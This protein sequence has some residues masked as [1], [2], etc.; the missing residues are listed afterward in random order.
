[1]SEIAKRYAKALYELDQRTEV[2]CQ[3]AYDLMQQPP[4]WEAL[5]SPVLQVKEKEHILKRL[6]DLQS[7][8]VY[9]S[10]YKLLVEKGRLKQLPEI[11]KELE[12][13]SCSERGCAQC[14]MHCVQIPDQQEQQALAKV[15]CRLHHK[16]EIQF[17]F[18]I[19]PELSGGFLLELDGITYDKSVRGVLRGLAGQMKERRMV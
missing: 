6:P 17:Q 1:M 3:I 10:F 13:L 18:V 14:T 16:Q 8:P 9:L 15:L 5:C 12:Q 11:L 19:E 2:F 4:L 7:E